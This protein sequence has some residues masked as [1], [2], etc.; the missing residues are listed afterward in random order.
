MEVRVVLDRGA[1]MPTK[2][3]ESDFYN[4]ECPICHKKFHLKPSQA[5]RFKTHCCS[6]ECNKKFR[7]IYMSGTGNHQYGLKGDKNS[8][9]KSDSKISR[10]GYRQIRV[11]DHPYRDSNDFVLEHRLVAEEYLLNDDNSI[12][13]NGKRY[14]KKE[15]VV[16]HINHNRLDNRPENLAVMFKSEHSKLHCKEQFHKRNLKGQFI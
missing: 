15:Y 5:K 2:A 10:Y 6:R 13:I 1:K 12:V 4:C 8:S 7:S 9:W 3:H 16:H 14:L 11:L